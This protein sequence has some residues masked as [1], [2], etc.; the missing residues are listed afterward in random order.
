MVLGGSA[1]GR[2]VEEA[3]RIV[4]AQDVVV[5]GDGIHWPGIQDFRRPNTRK[6]TPTA[7]QIR[8]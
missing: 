3:L 7:R 8:M 5:E 6:L 2:N 4:F 1:L